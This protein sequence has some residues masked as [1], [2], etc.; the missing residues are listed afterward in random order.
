MK[1]SLRESRG[2]GI[3]ALGG[4]I[5]RIS[6]KCFT[7]KS[8]HALGK[9]YTV[10]WIG[11]RWVCDCDDYVKRKKPCKHVYAVNFLLDLP[12]ILILN[13][14]AFE[15][16]CI[17]C[18][19]S[20]VKPKGFRY[21]KGGAV[22]LFRC[23]ACGKRF[24]ETVTPNRG[25]AKV[26]L[27]VIATDLYY[28]GLSLRDIKDHLWQVYNIRMSVSTIHRWVGKITDLLKKVSGRNLKL[29]VG[30]KWLADETVIKIGGE[31]KYL[32]NIMDHKTRT[33]IASLLTNGRGAE[34]ALAALKEAIKNAGKAPSILVTDSLKSY[35]KAVEML[36]LPLTHINNAGIAKRE[37][38]NRIE[39]LH[40]TIKDWVARKRGMKSKAGE[41][42]GGY[43]HYYNLIRPNT[44]TSSITKTKWISAIKTTPKE[45]V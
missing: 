30:E 41:L 18:G 2:F 5:K 27:A 12:K 35:Q 17:Y 34:E 39:R 23:R 42:L 7:V 32:W 26:A 24:S 15:R 4:Q 44:T 29:E 33:Y 43:R 40:G 36:G 31:A 37:N 45:T 38:N 25:G 6:E 1:L 22:R 28:K 21:N 14:E 11:S 19:S 16:R 20:E 9:F 10:K 13:A 8:Q 3:V